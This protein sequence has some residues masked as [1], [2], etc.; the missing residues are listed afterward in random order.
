M[1]RPKKG[2]AG[3]YIVTWLADQRKFLLKPKSTRGARTTPFFGLGNAVIKI[4]LAHFPNK[5]IRRITGESKN[6]RLVPVD[7]FWLNKWEV[8]VGPL[9]K[10]T[11]LI[12]DDEKKKARLVF[13]EAEDFVLTNREKDQEVR[14]GGTTHESCDLASTLIPY[15]REGDKGYEYWR[16][17]QLSSTSS[18]LDEC[19]AYGRLFVSINDNGVWAHGMDFN[20]KFFADNPVGFRK[21]GDEKEAA[22]IEGGYFEIIVRYGDGTAISGRYWGEDVV[23]KKHHN[24]VRVTSR[25]I[26]TLP[27]HGTGYKIGTGDAAVMPFIS[28]GE[29]EFI[30]S[31]FETVYGDAI[32]YI[33]GDDTM[34]EFP[35][36][37][38]VKYTLNEKIVNI[39][40]GVVGIWR[41]EYYVVTD[42]GSGVVVSRHYKT[43]KP[44]L[45]GTEIGYIFSWT[46]F[47]S[48]GLS[49]FRRGDQTPWGTPD[50]PQRY[51]SWTKHE[52]A[53]WTGW[54]ATGTVV[55]GPDMDYYWKSHEP[56]TPHL[57]WN[58]TAHYVYTERENETKL[59][60]QHIRS[61]KLEETPIA[62]GDS[63]GVMGVIEAVR[64]DQRGYLAQSKVPRYFLDGGISVVTPYFVED[65]RTHYD[66]DALSAAA[67]ARL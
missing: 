27:P 43:M 63:E 62:C 46:E 54:G 28:N 39:Y 58:R 60:V 65:P 15:Y 17:R 29:N 7:I 52:M 42:D 31:V 53:G 40:A 1:G 67:L 22:V 19:C 4:D 56:D 26:Y 23:R 35:N 20:G 6:T 10:R 34:I 51:Y 11:V 2:R 18:P 13:N 49:V 50:A 16:A 47:A 48:N 36:G 61:E 64:G 41:Y 24:I 5:V 8:H 59:F 12:E 55:G 66:A 32:V 30:I 38:T 44:I 21:G 57:L 45:S 37:E 25:N 14:F 9:K 33:D 3:E